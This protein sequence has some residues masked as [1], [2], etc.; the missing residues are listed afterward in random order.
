MPLLR[1]AHLAYNACDC[2]LLWGYAQTLTA[3]GCGLHGPA[4]RC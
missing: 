3:I 2:P 4:A 1:S